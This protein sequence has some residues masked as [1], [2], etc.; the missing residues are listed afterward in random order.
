[1]YK[2]FC[3]VPNLIQI[4]IN[5]V[6]LGCESNIDVELRKTFFQEFFQSRLENDDV[7]CN[8]YISTLIET[9]GNQN[10]VQINKK[11]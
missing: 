5:I 7:K 10:F 2:D 11:T 1:M 3:F 9:R 6:M 8:F 4:I